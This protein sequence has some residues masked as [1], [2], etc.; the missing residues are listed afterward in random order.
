M[1]NIK[2]LI[3]ISFVCASCQNEKIS[4]LNKQVSEL[5]N[6]NTKLKDSLAKIDY[7]KVIS[8]DLV[9]IPHEKKMMPGTSNKFSFFLRTQQK[10]PNYN[11][12]RI[13]KEGSDEKREL[14]IKDHDQ[15]KFQFD[16]IPK[17]N[18]DLSFELLAEFDLDSIKVLVSGIIDMSMK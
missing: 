1:R 12:Y 9:G 14:L 18:E 10:F 7:Q 16:F 15:S 2:L 11:V 6:L 13:T 17:S 8:T 4:E 5:R 3:L